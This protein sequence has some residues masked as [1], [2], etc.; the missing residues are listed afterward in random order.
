VVLTH[1]AGF[2]LKC[3]HPE[4]VGARLSEQGWPYSES[5]FRFG[6]NTAD[7]RVRMK[8]PLIG[9]GLRKALAVLRNEIPPAARLWMG[10]HSYG[11][12][13]ATMARGGGSTSGVLG[14]LLLSYPLH[15]PGKPQQLRTVTC[16]RY[17]SRRSSRM[18]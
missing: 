5:I 12:R 11:G 17:D 10:G 8:Q 3:C 6:K 18:V 15:P 4:A 16:R 7:H 13:Q 14:L 1:G 2:K 9:E